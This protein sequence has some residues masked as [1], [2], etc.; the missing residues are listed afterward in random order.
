MDVRPATASDAA[1]LAALRWQFR[2]GREQAVETEDAFLTRC[3][4]WMR[5]QLQSGVWRAWVAE[6]D[7]RIVGQVWLM[8]VPKLPNP[9]GEP[10]RHAYLSN[11]FVIP[12]VRGG[13]GS[14]LLHAALNDADSL[15]V[16]RVVLWP[17]PKS[18]T[19]YE[20]NG[21]THAGRVMERSTTPPRP[22]RS[23]K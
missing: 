11:L 22:A 6:A 18:V 12:A 5:E 17:S 8:I 10:D 14:R 1:S 23:R 19:L 3:E 2:A 21:F 20:R 4:R 13:A 15:G 16:D 9:V 7:R